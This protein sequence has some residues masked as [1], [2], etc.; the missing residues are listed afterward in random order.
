[1]LLE[2]NKMRGFIRL[3][4]SDLEHRVHTNLKSQCEQREGV[5]GCEADL[6]SDVGFQ[7]RLVNDISLRVAIAC[8][9]QHSVTVWEYRQQGRWG[10]AVTVNF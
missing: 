10:A 1:M 9:N 6:S 5:Q 8:V 7:K 3:K 2:L 4:P